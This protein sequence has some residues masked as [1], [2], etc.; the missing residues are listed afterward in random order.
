MQFYR[1]RKSRLFIPVINE[2]F[3]KN[4]PLDK[5][6]ELLPAEGDFSEKETSTG[7]KKTEERIADFLL[8]IGNEVFLLECQSYDDDSMAIRIAEYAF[9]TARNFSVWDIGKATIPMP[10]F[11][12][13]YLKETDRTP[14][15]T[16]ITFTF[17][18]GQKVLYQ[19][20][21]VLLADIT[22]E[23]IVE[24]RLFPYIPFYIARYETELA[25]EAECSQ[26]MEDLAYFRDEMAG[27]YESGELS[28]RELL[29]LK[30]FVNTIITHITDGN[31][32]EERLVK[33]MGGVVLETES[34][35]LLR[36]GREEGEVRGRKEGEALG[37]ARGEARGREEGIRS[38]VEL[39]QEVNLSI[40]DTVE[41]LV[42]KFGLSERVS[43]EKANQY[44]KA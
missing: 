5:E 22:K 11:A 42:S 26:A 2:T 29:D 40:A 30:G 4:Y 10:H 39:C 3:G 23:Y 19:A 13:I 38:V 12:V 21:N 37:E 1:S 31:K 34:E 20:D 41:K 18:D 27:L 43:A 15:K 24:K 8:K 16:E 44:W 25:G 35:R 32:A 14:E 9:I 6:S 17:P 7:E 28:A 36:V 33:V